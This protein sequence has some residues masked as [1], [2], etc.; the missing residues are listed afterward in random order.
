MT[1]NLFLISKVGILF[2]FIRICSYIIKS[3]LPVHCKR[4]QIEGEWI[5]PINL[6]IFNPDLNEFKK[7][8]GHGFSDKIE[9]I[10]GDINY[11]F[12]SFRDI[13]LILSKEYKIY[14]PNSSTVVGKWTPVYEQGFIVYN[15]NSI[16][17]AFMKFFLKQKTTSPN[18]SNNLYLSNCDKTM[19]GWVVNYQ[20]QN[21]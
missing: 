3:D 16:F 5:F 7:S 2:F 8:C 10:V 19:I 9:K 18:P 15:R 14:E 4:E 17:T 12:K 13:T 21:C 11:S 1:N 6:D 20:S